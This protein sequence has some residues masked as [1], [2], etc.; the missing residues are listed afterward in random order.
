MDYKDVLTHL[1][2]KGL[3]GVRTNPDGIALTE[4]YA[5]TSL[6]ID[7][8]ARDGV[9]EETLVPVITEML[10]TEPELFASETIPDVFKPEPPAL[11]YDTA[12]NLDD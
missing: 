9:T 2:A 3:Q 10:K 8:A 5:N 6:A 7:I 1:E 12:F 11:T 4:G